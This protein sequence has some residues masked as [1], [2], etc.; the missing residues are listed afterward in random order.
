MNLL[1]ITL[2][3]SSLFCSLIAGFVLAF[4]IVVMPGIRTLWFKQFVIA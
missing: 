3:P 4:A 1:Q 2:M